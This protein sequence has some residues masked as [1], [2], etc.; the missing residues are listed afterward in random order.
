MLKEP[1]DYVDLIIVVFAVAGIFSISG[2]HYIIAIFDPSSTQF[3]HN[4]ILG[5]S[6][7]SVACI[8]IS[9]GNCSIRKL[10]KTPA[11]VVVVWFSLF[12]MI[13]AI[14]LLPIVDR[15]VLP[16][17]P[18]E[19]FYIFMVGFFGVL[20]QIFVTLAFQL[21]HAAP[22]SVMES[23]N[24]AF[25]FIIQYYV[26]AEPIKLSS[27]IGAVILFV[28]VFAIGV[29]KLYSHKKHQITIDTHEST[30]IRGNDICGINIIS[31]SLIAPSRHATPI[32]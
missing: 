2:P 5:V 20:T 28:S 1:F 15:Y 21:E 22:I 9:C 11:P 25:S 26:F 30:I 4:D 19:W 29:K 10:S 13:C 32:K 16:E 17:S 8:A 12:S 14:I 24:V 23:F 18:L 7:A 27:I 31:D 3:S 6:L